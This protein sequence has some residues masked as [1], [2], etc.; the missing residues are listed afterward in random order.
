MNPTVFASDRGESAPSSPELLDAA[1]RAIAYLS[2]MGERPV[3]PSVDA[4]QRLAGFNYP[5]PSDPT[6]PA[7]VIRL[8]DD[9]G[10]PATTAMAG[11]RF[12]GFVIGGALPTALAANWLA[13]AWDQNATL[14]ESSPIAAT[15]E[16]VTERWL[17]DLLGLPS[18]TAASFV[19]GCTMAHFTA[20]AA[21]RHAVLKAVGW[22][23]PSQGL[24]GA[25]RV[26]VVVGEEAHASLFKVLALL[27]FGRDGLVRVPVDDQ[28]RMRSDALPEVSGPAIVCV[29]AG[30][31]NTGAFDPIRDVVAWARSI[32]AWV[33]VDGAFGLWAAAAPELSHLLDGV[34]LA[35]SWA[36]D[37]HKWLNVPYDSGLAFVRDPLA[38]TDV[39][40]T[41]AAYLQETEGRRE[42]S[43][44]TPESSRRARGVEIWAALLALGAN[45]VSDIVSRTCGYARRF[46]MQLEAAGFDILNDVVLNQV[47]VSFGD[48]E[49]TNR[50]IARVKEDGTCWCGGTVW[51]GQTAMRISVSSWATTAEDVDISVRAII[52]AASAV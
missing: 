14:F 32:G 6:D 17:V 12:F 15:L 22:D 31:V 29:Q 19:T 2:T 7:T 35:D 48:P 34:E 16:T 46:A 49:R 5:L 45:G 33:H 11:P 20:L 39:M 3:A 10:S 40:T 9:L 21:A 36:S 50:V 4:V 42:P 37:A 30:N 25:P 8:L 28:G 43:W 13:G 47:L 26:T 18:G 44:Y 24:F 52:A 27:G 23:V 38:L 51:Q 41:S 1:S